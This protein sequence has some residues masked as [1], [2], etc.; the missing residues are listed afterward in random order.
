LIVR[1]SLA[2]YSWYEQYDGFAAIRN[3]KELPR[4]KRDVVW[5]AESKSMTKMQRNCPPTR[6]TVKW[7]RKF[8]ATGSLLRRTRERWPV[9]GR[10]VEHTAIL[11]T[12]RRPKN[13]VTDDPWF[14]TR[15][16]IMLGK[17]IGIWMSLTYFRIYWSFEQNRMLT[18]IRYTD[19]LVEVIVLTSGFRTSRLLTLSLVKALF[20]ILWHYKREDGFD[21]S[22]AQ[23]QCDLT[24]SVNPFQT[25]IYSKVK[26]ETNK[27]PLIWC[28]FTVYFSQHVSGIIMPI[29]R[30]TRLLVVMDVALRSWDAS[31]VHCGK[32]FIF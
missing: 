12:A 15:S 16:A 25:S 3:V 2:V 26:K 17:Q 4:R 23:G 28:L 9:S 14:E 6:P 20:L 21:L 19:V 10:V 30:R 13:S 18:R 7:W 27:M 22:V 29:V 8:L 32:V 1:L 31:L 24:V 5:L 11:L